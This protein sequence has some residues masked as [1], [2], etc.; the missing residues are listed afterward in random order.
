MAKASPRRRQV[1]ALRVFRFSLRQSKCPSIYHKAGDASSR[2]RHVLWGYNPVC[3]VT[4]AIL[5]GSVSPECLE[6]M[7]FSLRQSKSPAIHP[8]AVTKLHCRTI[9]ASLSLKY[10]PASEPLRVCL[11]KMRLSHNPGFHFFRATHTPLICTM[12]FFPKIETSL[13]SPDVHRDGRSAGKEEAKSFG[14]ST[15]PQN[16]QLVA[17]ISNSKR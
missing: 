4:P 11:S 15:P 12:N 7:L 9:L 1:R 10:E 14:K 13:F 6:G 16:F 2:R 5:H 3:K 8:K 17:L